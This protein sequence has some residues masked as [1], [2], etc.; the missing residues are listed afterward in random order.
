MDRGYLVHLGLIDNGRSLG[1]LN[2][3]VVTCR[4]PDYQHRTHIFLQLMPNELVLR[5]LEWPAGPRGS[6][7]TRLA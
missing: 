5:R 3:C 1:H 2:A 7:A 4:P 6:E